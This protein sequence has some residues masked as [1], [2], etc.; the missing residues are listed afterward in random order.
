MTERLHSVAIG[1]DHPM[2]VAGLKTLLEPHFEVVGTANDGRSLLDLVEARRPDLVITDIAMP[3]ID[4]IEVARLLRKI[5][6]DTRVLILSIHTEASWVRAAFEAGA[7]AYLT[8]SSV[9]EEIETAVREVLKDRFY[10]SPVVARAAVG[11]PAET[12]ARPA[13]AAG[14]NLTPRE[15]EIVRLVGTGIGNKEIAHRLG[16]SVATV[17]THLSHVYGKLGPVSRVE[18]ALYAARVVEATP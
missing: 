7:Q 8:K 9:P 6:P 18:L 17:R 3:E 1:D 15:L 12:S 14:G 13:A 5:A 4:G 10:V 11:H 2:V 16:I